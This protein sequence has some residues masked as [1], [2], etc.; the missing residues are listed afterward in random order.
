MPQEWCICGERPCRCFHGWGTHFRSEGE[1]LATIDEEI[2]AQAQLVG[3]TGEIEERRRSLG[4]GGG[5][6]AELWREGMHPRDI[7][8]ELGEPLWVV[9]RV[10]KREKRAQKRRVRQDGW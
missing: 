6:I 3:Y 10:I 5:E 9:E 2:E 8:Q 1:L 7:A 4:S